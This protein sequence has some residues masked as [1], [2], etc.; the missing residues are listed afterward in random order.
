[1]NRRLYR[2]VFNRAL[3]VLQVVAEIARR[4]RG[5][6]A[7]GASGT[8]RQR[9][10]TVSI[11][12]VLAASAQAQAPDTGRITG[13]AHGPGAQRP[14]VLEAV[15][16]VPL[17]NI[18]T[19]SAAG[20]SHNRYGQFDVGG[21][22]AILNNARQNVRTELGG[23]VQ[24]NPRLARGTARVILNEVEGGAPSRLGGYIEVGG[25]RAEVVIANPAG[26]QADGAGF[27]N[28]SRA[29]LTT[30]RVA[31]TDD[32]LLSRF[33][34]ADGQI[35][36]E[37]RGLDASRTDY[38]EVIARAVQVNANV[39]ANELQ[40]TTGADEAET[41]A[42]AYAL[43]VGALGGMYANKIHL[44]GTEAG[45]GVRNA[46]TL[47]ARDG[48]L[49]LRADGQLVNSGTL[50]S[51][52]GMELA[53]AGGIANS[54][55]IRAGDTLALR[56]SQELDNRGGRLDAPRL[57]IE[58]ASL[59]NRGGRIAQTG[60]QALRLQAGALSNR[61][62]GR[63]GVAEVPAASIPADGTPPAPGTGTPAPVAAS[64]G[65]DDA[66][67][68]MPAAPAPA[69]LAPG[70]LRIAGR[71]D[72]DGGVIEAAR[73]GLDA[74]SGDLDN[75]GGRLAL[76]ALTLHNAALRNVGGELRIAGPSELA[77]TRLDNSAGRLWFGTP[78]SLR[79]GE[80]IN[81][82]GDFQHA[83]TADSALRVDGLLDNGQGG[84]ITGHGDLS[85]QAGELVNAGG[86]IEHTGTGTLMLAADAVSGEAG[87]LASAGTLRI[88]AGTVNLRG[89]SSDAQRVEIEADTLA[90]QTIN[91]AYDRRIERYDA[92]LSD[93]MAAA[94]QA[95]LNGDA[96][97]G[98]QL[99]WQA[100]ALI[101]ER[102]NPSF[103]KGYAW[104][105]AGTALSLI[106]GGN[107]L[108]T[109][110]YAGAS[111]V[112]GSVADSF[113]QAARGF[114]ET[115]AV[116]FRCTG[117]AA[118]CANAEPPQTGNLGEL[119]D[120]AGQN[121]MAMTLLD[122]I[123]EDAKVIGTNGIRN[124]LTRAGQLTLGHDIANLVDPKVYLQYND[125]KSALGDLVSVSRDKMISPLTGSYSATTMALG[126]AIVRQGGG[127]TAM[128][129][130]SR[131]TVVLANALSLAAA[132]GYKND[133]LSVFAIG[134]AISPGRI[135]EPVREI[136]GEGVVLSN[137]L[138]FLNHP[139]DFV[140]TFTGG[141]F[142]PWNYR[143]YQKG[144]DDKN[145]IRGA[146]NGSFWGSI[147]RAP[148]TFGFGETTPH[149]NYNLV[150]PTLPDGRDNPNNWT[151]EKAET[152]LGIDAK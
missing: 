124:S 133:E 145:Y 11:A 118:Q 31:F 112:L 122:E 39:W 22:G 47:G 83:G 107:L 82:G 51:P 17:V 76:D 64:P 97:T 48:G 93:T 87:R 61:E 66:T 62:G 43:D 130:H 148:Q 106:S 60:G 45:L 99:R 5:G 90:T 32:G 74:L 8:P 78:L 15:N 21:Q 28:A 73:I 10:I 80:F 44:V 4:I 150:K 84:R 29:T 151:V 141:M 54:G 94:A 101:D 86:T 20:V 103:S 129:G 134:P 38:T 142:L 35:S 123:P 18:A 88:R 57:E 58:A 6:G 12:L 14:V 143:P 30:G 135:A 104:A 68:P 136:I 116:E 37:G 125:Q 53:A 98:Q 67:P 144:P 108:D 85:V 71:L 46:G 100:Q 96:A 128:Y 119:R 127:Q 149:S 33:R 111:G 13:D 23:W 91:A 49:V 26:I 121:G 69:P 114:H 147:L 126:D 110:R 3:G 34:V 50:Q 117:S 115:L 36:I 140:S 81:R 70:E 7:S 19:P 139:N 105:A 41:K 59:R 92:R 1:M 72:N 152:L 102:D 113:E 65:T 120:W 77:L 63:I 40:V 42:P 25:D 79:A 131:G 138:V 52:V 146:T 95:E 24:G 16:E 55:A 2:I 9:A 137:A 132:S 109:A 75:S 56:T 89:A 27:I